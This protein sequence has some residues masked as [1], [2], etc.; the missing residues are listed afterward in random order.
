M[1]GHTAIKLDQVRFSYERLDPTSGTA[2]AGQ[3][4]SDVINIDQLHIERGEHL[5]IEGPSGCGKSTLLGLLGGINVAQSGTVEI[6]D[7]DLTEMT[8]R[9][10]DEFRASHIGFIFQMFNLLPYLS[11]L[12]NVTLPCKF[13][14]IRR[15][16]LRDSGGTVA[17]R[18]EQLLDSLG[19]TQLVQQ[20]RPVTE[21][22]IGQQQRVAAARALIGAPEIVIA[23]E[24]T[25]ALDNAASNRFIELLFSECNQNGTTLIVV[26]H[27]TALGSRF[28]RRVDLPTINN[29]KTGHEIK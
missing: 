20:R 2:Q 5:F 23:D 21:L 25:S 4:P 3:D 16:R 14:P 26:S 1:S 8:S 18:A 27:D 17:D 6:L 29:A 11:M 15:Q 7:Q 9:Q 28:D 10:R 13:S 19:L 22:S 12:E 24:P